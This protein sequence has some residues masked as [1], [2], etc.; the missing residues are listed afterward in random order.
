[1]VVKMFK[2][3]IICKKCGKTLYRTKLEF[4]LFCKKCYEYQK[5]EEKDTTIFDEWLNNN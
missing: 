4:R 2:T 5:E 3:K 1:M